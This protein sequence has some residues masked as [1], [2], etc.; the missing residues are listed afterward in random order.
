MALLPLGTDIADPIERLESLLEWTSA[1]KAYLK[2]IPAQ[3]FTEYMGFVPGMAMRAGVIAYTQLKIADL[4]GSPF[5]LIVTNVPASRDPIY[6]AQSLMVE[7]DAAGPIWD[8]AGLLHVVTSYLTTINISYDA[9][10]KALPDS[11]FYRECLEASRRE[12]LDAVEER[13]QR[14]PG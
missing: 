12:L 10:A 3:N 8:G 2:A 6:F 9:D 14:A 11:K 5:N 13:V 1:K 7:Y 4:M